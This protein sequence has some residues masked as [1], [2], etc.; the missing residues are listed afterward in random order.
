MLSLR[1]ELH[2]FCKSDSLSEEGLRQIIERHECDDVGNYKFFLEAICN[3]RVTDGIIRCLLEYFP[4][5]ASLRHTGWSPLCLACNRDMTPN[6]ANIIRL[7]V[8]AAPDSVGSAD[9]YGDFPLH[10]LCRKDSLDEM[11]AMQT[12]KLLLEKFPEAVRHANRNGDL[13]IHMAASGNKSPE[14]CRVL[15]EAYPG[16]E[17]MSNG[18]G[19]FPLH[20]AC[21]SNT[22][23]A[24]E[25]LYKLYPDA[26]NHAT[27]IGACPIHNAIANLTRRDNPIAAVDIVKF[28]LDCNPNVKLQ[29]ME[30]KSL[31]AYACNRVYNG[32][33]IH[34]GTEMIAR[35][36]KDHRL[37][38]TPDSDGQ[39]PL[40]TA[41]QNNVRLGSIKLLL[42]G[43]PSA[44][45][46]LENNF[47]LPLHIAC[48]YHESADVIQY[49][50]G[51][52]APTLDA[53]DRDG[54]TTLHLA[55]RS[56]S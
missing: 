31:L 20:Y 35:Q 53:V 40:H 45:R 11:A 28:M 13:P 2:E 21:A 3:E 30:R 14:F 25:Y 22:V 34:A 6:I 55:C 12:L 44:L 19:V 37:M 1:S 24:V 50:V 43:N 15:I 54:N 36:A 23:A 41:L 4:D 18:S 52:D 5:A 42:K 38:T 49:L 46:T 8:D 7:L 47:A 48:E 27:T 9:N 17:R 51:L 26:I 29:K 39:L 33:N 10:F 16:S 32:S 56:G